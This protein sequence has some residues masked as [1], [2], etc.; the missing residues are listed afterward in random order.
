[1]SNIHYGLKCTLHHA[2]SDHSIPM[3]LA[4]T[5]GHLGEKE[6]DKYINYLTDGDH[7]EDW[8]EKDK[9]ELCTA[10]DYVYKCAQRIGNN[11]SK[12][13]SPTVYPSVDYLMYRTI[14]TWMHEYFPAELQWPDPSS[15]SALTALAPPRPLPED[16]VTRIEFSYRP[17]RTRFEW[18][19]VVPPIYD[20]IYEY[21][22]DELPWYCPGYSWCTSDSKGE[23]EDLEEWYCNRERPSRE[24]PGEL[25]HCGEKIT[26]SVY[27]VETF[28]Q[29]RATLR[30]KLEKSI[31][32]SRMNQSI[33]LSRE[34]CCT[35]CISD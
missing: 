31:N 27:R 35:T 4:P 11:F 26:T 32:I 8:T 30:K 14:P 9:Q 2:L 28:I 25:C 16:R 6:G 34:R 7:C 12:Q 3:I 18:L 29:E 1:M 19:Q 33:Y 13:E 15:P 20:G 22:L 17:S 10:L 21:E 5:T 23:V 24:P